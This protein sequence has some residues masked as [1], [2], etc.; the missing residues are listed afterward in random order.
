MELNGMRTWHEQRALEQREHPEVFAAYDAFLHAIE[1]G[2]PPDPNR[3]MILVN[4]PA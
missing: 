4:S 1:A 3:P 2:S